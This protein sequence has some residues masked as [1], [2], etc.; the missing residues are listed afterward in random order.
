M[1]T[2][3]TLFLCFNIFFV[4]II[5]RRFRSWVVQQKK[6]T[7][8][9]TRNNIVIRLF[10]LLILAG[11]NKKLYAQTISVTASDCVN[12]GVI[13]AGGTIGSGGPYQLS[14]I[15]YPAAY[16]PGAPHFTN[17]L[18][19]TFRALF[20]GTYT[21][22]VIDQA[23]TFFTYP[24]IVVGGS[25]TPPG[26]GAYLP[27]ASP[28][29]NCALGNG[30]ITGVM[31]EG[32]PPFTYQVLAG[33]A[34]AG[35]I[36]STGTF[37]GLPAG[38]YQ[39]QA[40]DS[41]YN[42]QTRA[43]TIAGNIAYPS[44]TGA[45]VS[46]VNCN[47]F[48]LDS[49][50]TPPAFPQGGRFEIIN[51]DGMG[52]NI[53]RASGTSLPVSFTLYSKSDITNGRVR[54]KLYDAC[55]NIAVYSPIKYS[56]AP[57]YSISD[58]VVDKISCDSL[59]IEGANIT[60]ALAPGTTLV[61]LNYSA[62]SNPVV[63]PVSGFPFHFRATKA[64]LL[65][66]KI[67]IG[68]M[69]SC[70]DFVKT[71]PVT[72]VF[73]DWSFTTDLLYTCNGVFLNAVDITGDLVPPYI[74][75]VKA[76]FNSFGVSDSTSEQL[77]TSFPVTIAGVPNHANPLVVSVTIIDSCGEERKVRNDLSFTVSVGDI[78]NNN[79]F[80]AGVSIQP[81][82]TYS[83]PVT[84]SV[85]PGNI[86]GVNT[87]GGFL[88]PD[89]VYSFTATD[90]CGRQ[91]STG[92]VELSR[93]WQL[94][95]GEQL[96]LCAAGYVSNRIPVPS[97]SA[98]QLQVRQ[99]R[100]G[101][102][103]TDSSVL[104]Q[105]V[106]FTSTLNNCLS[107]SADA[108]TGEWIQ[109][110]ST[111]PGD[112][113]TYIV[114]DTCGHSDTLS[115]TNDSLGH[116]PF[117]HH[118]S[119]KNKCINKG[120]II[121]S[122]HDDGPQWNTVI[123]GV[124]DTNHSQIVGF[125]TSSNTN[126]DAYPN[127]QTI[128]SDYPPGRYFVEYSFSDC[129]AFYADTVYIDTYIQPK[130]NTVQEL[131]QCNGSGSEV[132]VSGSAGVSPYSYQVVG[133]TP[134]NFTTGPQN[135]PVFVL[136]ASQVTVTVRVLDA[137]LNSITRT[138]AVTTAA[139]PVIRSN[140][141]VFATCSF[142]FNYHLF[143]DSVYEG[144][145]FEWRKITG[146]GAGPVVIGRR[147]SVPL[148]YNTIADTGTY[149]V[150]VTV[151][152]SCYDMYAEYDVANVVLTCLPGI[153]GTI[154]DDANGLTD[155][156]VNGFGT[157][158]GGL[159]VT[160]V[161]EGGNN[162]AVSP[163][164]ADGT[165]YFLDLAAGTYTA[166][167]ST[168][169]GVLNT[170]PPGTSLPVNWVNTGEYNSNLP[171]NDGLVNSILT[172]IVVNSSSVSNAN[173]GI[174]QKPVANPVTGGPQPNPGG[175]N[176]VSIPALNGSDAEDG[177]YDGVSGI[178]T[179]IIQTVPSNGSLYYN[180]VLLTP[181]QI[182]H[183]YDPALLTLDPVDGSVIV[184]FTYA[185]IDQALQASNPELVTMIFKNQPIANTDSIFTPKN[186][187]VTVPVISNDDFGGD[188]P[189]MGAIQIIQ[190]PAH[191]T[192]S[193]ATNNTFNDP[194]DDSIVYT[195]ATDYTG[196]DTLIY[197]ICDADGD[198]DTALVI[199]DIAYGLPV[200]LLNFYAQTGSSYVDLVWNFD[201]EMNV[202]GYDV[203]L[204]SDGVHFNTIGKVRASGAYQYKWRHLVPLTGTSYYRLKTIDK[205][206][207][208]NY[209]K[210][211]PVKFNPAPVIQTISPN[212]FSSSINVTMQLQRAT[213]VV[214]FMYDATGR[215]VWQHHYNGTA[216]SN[217]FP[218]LSLEGLTTGMYIINVM[219]DNYSIK[220]L[221][222]KR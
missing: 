89:G 95:S 161:N 28:V 40:A 148:I 150:R 61:L 113:Y 181:A 67:K 145:V 122:W 194:V 134:G 221:L 32:K 55:G 146:T 93:S 136:P 207:T 219:A 41:C 189:S 168:T 105:T 217:S 52:G 80:N 54:I 12:T 31:T 213:P 123:V 178:N 26:S 147:P 22:Q 199:I 172:G 10:L 74:I 214:M 183:Q 170:P 162:V 111:L 84:F 204:S 85:S 64:Q 167:L 11:C 135:N 21:L 156:T 59:S 222:F 186:I 63:F 65:A 179:V 83:L 9:H 97:R 14:L 126:L 119:V 112:T 48:S 72:G 45:S 8:P 151:P 18:P 160:L 78:E 192:A 19:D 215:I 92:P 212:P 102:P 164:R 60:P 56:N 121:A 13:A 77:V 6:I 149:Q 175:N 104:L 115:L 44:I 141:P 68:I 165:Y 163:V 202:A 1:L 81:G 43:V 166:V 142:P 5:R 173:F 201:A 53:T 106:V 188:G 118:A 79:C 169:A 177:V 184:T 86:S 2:L 180:N 117:Y 153:S 157:D 130:I 198:C 25:Y 197:Q 182:I 216:G 152:N 87:S 128:L 185:E 30:T 137:C 98:G 103:V 4:F 75:K 220:K 29:T 46:I 129:N 116:R 16:T 91:D 124:F 154:L 143:V 101:M 200:R 191:G 62:G 33:P 76:F 17:Q 49:L 158:A 35:A 34:Q 211:L 37:T 206:G 108:S 7:L 139:P 96:K 39:L 196:R 15:N 127:G 27:V 131:L 38:T 90:A 36:N 20:P 195:P 3:F 174:E 51:L 187:P 73:N 133:T 140:P 109:F 88:L 203:L 114:T 110:D 70:G 190:Q 120:D 132:I 66:N 144:S 71:Y 42:I 193:V 58:V 69:D 205:N 125:Y 94:Q 210:I 208:N 24:G 176:R 209:S 47:T 107:C 50:V 155:N 218:L 159:Y 100:G 138:I 23:G 99:Y 82:G 57:N 171:G